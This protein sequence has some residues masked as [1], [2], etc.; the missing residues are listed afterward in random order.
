MPLK[1]TSDGEKWQQQNCHLTKGNKE[2]DS[3]N[4]EIEIPNYVVWKE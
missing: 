4:V 3:S 2:S 1:W